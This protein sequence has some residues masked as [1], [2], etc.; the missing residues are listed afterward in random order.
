MTDDDVICSPEYIQGVYTVFSD[1]TVDAAQGRVLLDCDGTLPEW[2][3]S[4]L[5]KF[6]SLRD[7][8]DAMRPWT[9]TLTGSNM[10]VRTRAA[11]RVGGFAPELGPGG[12]GFAEDTEFSLRLLD[13]GCRFVYAPQ[14]L[15][16]HQVPG[17]RLAKSVFRKRYFGLGRSHAYYASLNAPLWRFGVYAG[18]HWL[19]MQAKSLRLRVANRAAEALDCECDALKQAGFFWQHCQFARGVPRKLS[20]VTSWPGEASDHRDYSYPAVSL[21]SRM[22]SQ[23]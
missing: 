10:I 1:H 23:P 20:R 5:I 4:Q 7:Y 21:E 8:G 17:S 12:T 9:E 19:T 14:I 15:V 3:S 16:R 22:W 2:M 6:M 18:K 11:R 13:A